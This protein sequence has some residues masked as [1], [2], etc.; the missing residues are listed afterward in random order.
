MPPRQL[1]EYRRKRDFGKT[2]EP[3]GD[4]PV[5]AEKALRFVIQ[6]H[7]ARHLHF[8]LRLELSGVMKSWAVPKGPSLDTQEKRLAMEVEDHPIA[9]NTFEGTIP[10]G[11]YG[12]GTVMLWD[13]GT[14]TWNGPGDAQKNMREGLAQGKLDFSLHGERLHGSFALVRIRKDKSG[15]QPWLLIKHTDEFVETRPTTTDQDKSVAS[16]RT[17]AQIA[18]GDSAVW[19]SNRTPRENTA[20]PPSFEP[21]KATLAAEPPK[22]KTWQ[23]EPKYDGYRILGLVTGAHVSL[24]T[25]NGIDRAKDFPAVTAALKKVAKG[26]RLVIDGELVALAGG[27]PA[28]FQALQTHG[29]TGNDVALVAFDLLLFEEQTFASEPL[30]VRRAALEKFLKGRLPPALR[31][32]EVLK[33]T[34][35]DLLARARK[36]GWEGLIAKDTRSTYAPGQRSKQWLK[37][38]LEHRQEFVVGGYTEPTGSRAHLGALLIGYYDKDELVYAGHVGGG[39]SGA[40]LDHFAKLLSPLASKACPFAKVPKTNTKAHWL[41]PQMVVEVRFVQWTDEGVL[42]QPILIGLREDKPARMVVREEPD[43]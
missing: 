34:G 32:G 33:G 42:R 29:T 18:E 4:Q 8:D 35:T 40:S 10:K 24:L 15:K 2:R 5:K 14:Y 19:H 23:Y 43:Q 31:L 20:A 22:G 36:L 38:K 1:A 16:G 39:F 3:S 21:M 41:L 13:R 30:S 37:L 6:K 17:M 9:Y 11:E 12:G 7:A 27:K 28:R 26:K 25:R